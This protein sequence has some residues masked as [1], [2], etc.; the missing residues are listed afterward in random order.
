MVLVEEAA[1]TSQ[2]KHQATTDAIREDTRAS[3]C[4]AL[5]SIA[6]LALLSD[7]QADSRV[8]DNFKAVLEGK[9]DYQGQ[10]LADRIN[11]ELIVMGSFICLTLG[12]FFSSLSIMMYS[13][14]ALVLVDALIVVP[15][16]P[17]YNKY[18]TKWLPNRPA[19]PQEAQDNRESK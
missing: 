5:F 12:F 14:A 18:Q 15:A 17:F 10:R 13:L 1:E 16:W 3:H 7:T 4:T 19:S 6:T 9:I 8:M 2:K 11:Q